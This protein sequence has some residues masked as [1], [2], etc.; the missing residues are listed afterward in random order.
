MITT[1][2]IGEW[3]VDQF[4]DESV[5]VVSSVLNINDITRNEGDYTK[6][7][8]VPASK[9]NNILFRHWYD[10]TIDNGF[11]ARLRITGRINIDNFN[12]KH[13]KFRL[14]KVSVKKGK[15]SAYTI[16]FFG[17]L[18][19]LKDIVKKDLLSD[20]DLSAFDHDYDSDNVKAGLRLSNFFQGDLIYTLL[21]KKQYY[22]NSD[23][24][25]NVQTDTLSNIAYGGG[26]ETGVVWND[27]RAAIKLIK[28]IEAIENRF[29]GRQITELDVISASSFGGNSCFLT[30][31]GTQHE[32]DIF[33]TT[34]TGNAL[35][36]HNF[37]NALPNYTSTHTTGTR[38]VTVK[39]DDFGSQ[40]ITLWNVN[41]A[42]GMDVTVTT[43]VRGSNTNKIVFS[44]DFFGTSEFTDLFMWLNPDKDKKAGGDLN[45]IDWNSG[46]L[47]YM[48]LITNTGSYTVFD[49]PAA[50]DSRNYRLFCQ[51]TPAVGFTDVAYSIIAEVDGEDYQVDD[52]PT[53]QQ[54]SQ[55]LELSPDGEDDTTHSVR[56]KVLSE[57][58]F[59]Y[60]ALLTQEERANDGTLIDFA[61]NNASVQINESIF[62]VSE[63]LPKMKIID[64]LKGLF[65]MFKLV[66]VAQ[67]D[68]TYFVDTLDSYYAGGDLYNV[69]KYID[70][71]SYDVERGV[72][73]NEIELKFKEPT[74]ILNIQFD[75]NNNRFYGDIEKVLKDDEGELL[76][77]DTLTFELP[78]EQI[79]YERLNDQLGGDLTQIQYGAIIDEELE[80]ANP[81]AHI[82]Y[83]VTTNIN[84]SPIAFI[85]DD[86][87]RIRINGYI[88][89]PFHQNKITQPNF[90]TIF[91]REFSTWD[92]VAIE[93]TLYKNHYDNYV[94]NIFNIKKRTFKY[95]AQLPIHIITKLELNDTLKIKGN[96]YRIDKYSYNLLTGKTTFNLINKFDSFI[97]PLSTKTENIT[98][99]FKS[100]TEGVVVTNSKNVSPNKI[101]QGDGTSWATI[102]NVNDNVFITYDE[103][104]STEG[105]VRSMFIQYVSGGDTVNIF[106][107]QSD[108]GY[109]PLLDFSDPRNSQYLPIM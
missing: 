21:A 97:N 2:Y 55:L 40:D 100:Q 41:T 104:N 9:R 89:T 98:V 39:A 83:N 27:L 51:I 8:T 3:R 103:F 14:S 48:N 32:I 43:T 45:I 46:D 75:K 93:N 37:V 29:D 17:N 105:A 65:N 54:Q 90:S 59:Q 57:Q 94:S 26:D 63:E 42:T 102:T 81:K 60:T 91:N 70:F 38:L 66:V 4:P 12:F 73:L 35:E 78:F 95:T 76:D 22:Y 11:D 49:T 1:L 47:T 80:P 50:G 62:T 85:E 56:W 15:P 19:S 79:V 87:V 44:R 88:N 99:D 68:G 106:T 71:E 30:L 84:S 5:D 74:T 72:I 24:N 36:I 28:L 20:L 67:D 96:Y 13:G 16:N 34:E 23:S 7:F 33:T 101:N 10:A 58:E 53:G 52:Y 25:D 18:P 31:D 92:G 109:I 107:S 86:N 77:G 6:T 64:F 82:F 61:T 69:T 108:K